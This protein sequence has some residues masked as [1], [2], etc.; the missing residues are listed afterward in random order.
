MADIMEQ[1]TQTPTSRRHKNRV[2]QKEST[3]GT[4]N[5]TNQTIAIA[6]ATRN[7]QAQR[8]K[9]RD[10]VNKNLT[11]PTPPP[12]QIL[13][14]IEGL[15]LGDTRH[16]SA[17]KK[18]RYGKKTGENHQPEHI[19]LNHPQSPAAAAQHIAQAT[20]VKTIQLY[21]GPNFH[22]SPAPSSLPIPR[23]VS[24]SVVAERAS[25]PVRTPSDDSS[26][27]SSSQHG[28]DSP[29][30]R[31]SLR[32]LANDHA[33]EAS[34]LDIFFNAD[35]QEK[36]ERARL[37][38]VLQDRAK[39]ASP[40][41]EISLSSPFVTPVTPSSEETDANMLA[42]KQLLLFPQAQKSSLVADSAQSSPF[43]DISYR[44]SLG[45]SNS[46]T[47]TPT[48]SS[49]NLPRLASEKRSFYGSPNLSSPLSNTG[50]IYIRRPLPHHLRQEFLKSLP[51]DQ[52]PDISS[53]SAK[54]APIPQA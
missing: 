32:V 40:R 22:T 21:A 15:N 1:P 11:S 10:I 49:L 39:S 46:E 19:I 20:P 52:S 16:Q 3:R 48:V 53:K 23:F 36:A 29:T 28:G 33:R 42:L 37:S 34:P 27:E 17:Q 8:N 54:F 5:E 26:G 13:P 2:P 30:L 43:L 14:S 51:L 47:S 45:R 38:G 24:R 25:E 9:P 4:Q 6:N 31:N 12:E 18:K 7:H 35:R 44:Q 41:H 50:G